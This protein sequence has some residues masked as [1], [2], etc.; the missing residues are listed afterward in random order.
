MYFSN[1][2][3]TMWLEDWRRSSKSVWAYAKESGLNPRTFAKWTKAESKEKSCFVEVPA[4]VIKE[5][6]D[7]PEILVEKGDVRIHIPVKM[8]REELRTVMEGLGAAL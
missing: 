3:K 4:Q 1:E 6:H 5:Q 2:E 8:S 7:V